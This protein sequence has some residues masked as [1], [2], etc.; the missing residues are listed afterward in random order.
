MKK[1]RTEV[2]VVGSG[3]CGSLVAQKLAGAGRE[4]LVLEAGK[5]Y[6]LETRSER[7]ARMLDYQENPFPGDDRKGIYSSVGGQALHWGGHCPRLTEEDFRQFT[8][9]G[10]GL[11]WPIDYDDLEPHYCQAERLLGVS[12]EDDSWGPSRS[13]PFP[14]PAVPAPYSLTWV[15]NWAAKAGFELG[16]APYARNSQEYDG[17]PACQRCDTCYICPTGA[18]FSPDLILKRLL[19]NES[20]SLLDRTT[21]N[22][23]EEGPGQKIARLHCSNGDDG[24]VV[25]A[26]H[27]VL[28]GGTLWTAALLKASQVANSSGLVGRGIAGHPRISALFKVP[29]PLYPG[30]F[31][32]LDLQTYRF[33]RDE[34]VRFACRFDVMMPAPPLRDEKGDLLLGDSMMDAWRGEL[35]HGLVRMWGCYEVPPDEESTVDI[36][37]AQPLLPLRNLR[38]SESKNSITEK[39]TAR[40]FE[41]SRELETIG[42]KLLKIDHS[43]DFHHPAGGCRM[44]TD[45]ATSVCNLWGRSHDYPN[46]WVAGAPLCHTA[47]CSSLSL[48]FAALALRTAERLSETIQ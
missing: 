45:P 40:Y 31:N 6:A 21:A 39:V 11:D 8:R 27:F 30:Q 46:L 48:T 7:R 34:P 28:A 22:R 38:W 43:D 15:K 19:Q 9:L 23:L 18:K 44:G 32:L 10:T 47:G 16:T 5:S 14:M 36:L 42:A 2:C 35:D 37:E 4:I 29:E 25:E 20:I 33:M 41:L 3:L 12:G 1:I 13:A 24:L 17:R 26:D